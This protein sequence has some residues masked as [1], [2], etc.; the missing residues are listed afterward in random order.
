M[1]LLIL[2]SKLTYALQD[3]MPMSLGSRELFV[4]YFT[5]FKGHPRLRKMYE[6]MGHEFYCPF[7]ACDVVSKVHDCVSCAMIKETLLNHKKLRRL[8]HLQDSWKSSPST[9]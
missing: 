1:G 5:E 7:V 2:V 4:S 8:F 6:T 3:V 9:H